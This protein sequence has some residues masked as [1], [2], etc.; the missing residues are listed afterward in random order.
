MESQEY[1][2]IEFNFFIIL[3]SFGQ[4][5]YYYYMGSNKTDKTKDIIT[6]AQR[7]FYEKGL[8]RTSFEDIANVCGI[9]KALISYHFGS[10]SK[11]GGIVFSKYS[12][13]IQNCLAIQA[14]SRYPEYDLIVISTA[15]LMLHLKLYKEDPKAFRFYKEF[16][17][18]SFEDVTTGIEYF[19]KASNRQFKSKID[20]ETL[21]L[22]Y[23]SSNYAARGLIY[24]YFTGHI[25]SS[26]EKFE[27]FII[28]SSHKSFMIPEME[29][30][31]IIVSGKE[32]L[33]KLNLKICD[34]FEV[35]P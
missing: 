33:E 20:D 5:W 13:D 27:E 23:I 28:K 25:Q 17:D 31:S 32:L 9:S 15:N 4:M 12:A 14:Y 10:K 18:S 6:T 7:L 22:I 19:Y 8:K 34:Y 3:Y 11:L 26:F 2:Q 21:H 16:M 35:R 1:L 24:N 30:D 29:I